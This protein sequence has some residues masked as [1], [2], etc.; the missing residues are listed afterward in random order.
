MPEACDGC[1]FGC[2]V[3][4]RACV[5][6]A[7]RTRFVNR[8]TV[9]Q[10]ASRIDGVSCRP[11]SREAACLPIFSVAPPSNSFGEQ[12][13][14]R[15]SNARI[16]DSALRDQRSVTVDDAQ[17][18]LWSAEI[19]EKS[20]FEVFELAYQAWYRGTPDTI[21]LERI[22]AEYMFDGVVP[23]WVR[24]FTRTTLEAH[25]DWGW[26]EEMEVH[27]YLGACLRAASVSLYSTARLALS[28]FLPQVVFPWIDAD[29]AAF[30]A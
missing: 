2:V 7:T 5:E 23:F 8:V 11:A 1:A 17:M 27:Q 12:G 18:V 26:D 10:A 22:F 6:V 19:L 13:S 21:R 9:P 20:E 16:E 29:F 30:P 4:R 28:L 24:Q 15:S 3:S 14:S 25:D